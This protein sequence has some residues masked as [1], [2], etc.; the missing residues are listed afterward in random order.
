MDKTRQPLGIIGMAHKDYDMLKRWYDYYAAQVGPEN[1]FLY[2]H[3]ND[4]QHRDIAAGAN[5]INAPRDPSMLKFDL[6]RWTM[7]GAF[8]SGMLNFYNWM[9]VTDIDE[10][11]VVDPDV[12]GGLVPYLTEKFPVPAFMPPSI[13]PLGL[14]MV[15]VPAQE[16]A[17]LDE[18]RP[19][20]AQ[21]RYFYP[22]RMYS[23]PTLVSR[24]VMFGPG[25][26]RNDLGPRHLSDDLYLI[27]LKMHDGDALEAQFN[28]QVALIET[29]AT[30]NAAM[31]KKHVWQ[32]SW[33]AYRNVV[34]TY[35]LGPEDI[36]LTDIRAKM[37]DGQKAKFKDRYVF[38]NF[39]NKTLFQ[40]PE[41]FAN[42]V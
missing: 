33:N 35:A 8:A 13:S 17:P 38:G 10:M 37:V 28:H 12:A 42:L 2:S 18:S 4:P 3:G 15:H 20:L 34:D 16:P 36:R 9:L 21:R 30:Q 32:D 24:P 26:H 1:L 39:E 23:K 31:Q 41:R 6:R 19:V 22:S 29:A 14:N 5:V 40:L 27:H 25:G 11:V 7:L